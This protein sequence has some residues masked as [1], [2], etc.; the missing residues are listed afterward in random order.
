MNLDEEPYSRSARPVG[1]LH[2]GLGAFHR[3]HQAVYFDQALRS[4]LGEWGIFG[5]SPRSAQVTETLRRQNFLYTVNE[6]EGPEENPQVIASVFDGSVFD[7]ENSEFKKAVLSKELKVITITVT[8]KAYVSV[9][10][11]ESMPNRLLDILKLR[12]ETQLPL[13]TIIS[14]DNLPSNGEFL[15]R[16][17]MTSALAHGFSGEF[18]DAL[19]ALSIPNSMVDRIVPAITSEAIN[20]F[21]KKFGYRDESLITTEKFRQWV[22]GHHSDKSD[23]GKLGIEIAENIDSYEKLKLRLFNGAHSTTAYCGQLSGIEFIYQV[24]RD[25]RWLSFLE[26]LQ[27]QA[28]LSFTPPTGI[29]PTRYAA[30]ARSRM[31]NSALPHRT[32]QIAMDGSAKLPQRLFLTINDLH[33]LGKPREHI[34]FAIALW[35]RFL[36]S[37]LP[38]SDPLSEQLIKGARQ[39]RSADSIRGVMQIS[40]LR[41]PVFESEWPQIGTYLDD[42]QRY[43][44]ME[45]A[46][47]L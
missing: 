21:E 10:N 13:P 23:L 7:W 18:I 5:I 17:L 19:G 33:R 25:S 12:F 16:I 32:A 22:V 31:S 47:R 44:P 11:P 8:E 43:A 37:G 24:M 28:S 42:L 39:K 35:I 40:E 45:I 36:Q 38:V 2:F 29:A 34:A 4:G 26:K 14:C 6:C 15:E 9:P 30:I 41:N 3:G 27:E 1:V 46:A 20:N